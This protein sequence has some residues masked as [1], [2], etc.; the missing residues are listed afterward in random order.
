[1]ISAPI[2]LVHC[3]TSSFVP[4]KLPGNC[5]TPSCD[6]IADLPVL[7]WTHMAVHLFDHRHGH[8]EEFSDFPEADTVLNCPRDSGV[9]QNMR[10]HALKSRILRSASECLSDRFD[11]LAIELDDRL[12]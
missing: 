5:P 3:S 7:V 10:R 9:P 2:R 1:M 12:A 11:R 8:S 4:L 6:R